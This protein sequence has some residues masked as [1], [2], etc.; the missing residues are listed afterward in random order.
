[1]LIFPPK[2]PTWSTQWK[3]WFQ[4]LYEYVVGTPWYPL[5]LS[6]SWAPNTVLQ[7]A[8]YRK[9]CGVVEVQ[10]RIKDGTLT[11]G[12]VVAT[13]PVGFRPVDGLVFC[14]MN[15]GGTAVYTRVNSNGEIVIYYADNNTWL[16]LSGISFK[17]EQ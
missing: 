4:K 15:S 9:Y 2:S 12:T 1:M 7:T 10:G 11:N 17:A 14:Q 3:T 16:T 13:L 8:R 5:P 6:N